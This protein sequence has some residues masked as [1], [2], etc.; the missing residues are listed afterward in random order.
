MLSL[1]M[2]LMMLW[3]IIVLM[4]MLLLLWS[5]SCSRGSMTIIITIITSMT[6]ITIIT[7]IIIISISIMIIPTL[8]ITLIGS[9]TPLSDPQQQRPNSSSKLVVAVAARGKLPKLPEIR[10]LSLSG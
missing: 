1:M 2:T 5:H 7:I 8:I 4:L 6:V 3:M 10:L 9:S